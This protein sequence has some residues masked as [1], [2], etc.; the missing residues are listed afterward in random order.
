LFPDGHKGASFARTYMGPYYTTVTA[1]CQAHYGFSE[2]ANCAAFGILNK[3]IH[4][5][6]VSNVKMVRH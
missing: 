5:E 6:C 3:T 1:E 4:L 2:P